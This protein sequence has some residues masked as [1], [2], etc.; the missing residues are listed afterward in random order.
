MQ[1]ALASADTPGSSPRAELEPGPAGIFWQRARRAPARAPL[2]ADTLLP[3]PGSPSCRSRLAFP[4]ES[5]FVGVWEAS[6]LPPQRRADSLSC[7]SGAA[8]PSCRSTCT[9]GSGKPLTGSVVGQRDKCFPWRGQ[10]ILP[11]GFGFRRRLLTCI[12]A[13]NSLYFF[14]FPVTCWAV[15]SRGGTELCLCSHRRGGSWKE[16]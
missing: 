2:P 3:V 5:W 14:I 12:L 13:L 10:W 8:E 7:F 6:V 1:R 15:E 4:A 11:C 16:S 9:D